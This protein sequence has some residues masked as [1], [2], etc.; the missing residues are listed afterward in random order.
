MITLKVDCPTAAKAASLREQAEAYV[1]ENKLP[2]LGVVV[3]FGGKLCG[4]MRSI[5][6]D[7]AANGH[8]THVPGCIAVT[9]AGSV[10]LFE[11]FGGN[12]DAGAEL[13]AERAIGGHPLP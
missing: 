7:R 10:R 13:W 4:W 5:E 1:A 3:F 9:V 6:I 12:D 11:A 8:T 2:P